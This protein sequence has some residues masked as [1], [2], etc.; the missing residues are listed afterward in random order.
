MAHDQYWNPKS[1][2]HHKNI[3]HETMIPTAMIVKQVCKLTNCGRQ[4]IYHAAIDA[5]FLRARQFVL[6]KTQESTMRPRHEGREILSRR[7]IR[8]TKCSWN[9][10]P[11]PWWWQSTTR[12]TKSSSKSS[13]KYDKEQLEANEDRSTDRPNQKLTS[14][15]AFFTRRPNKLWK[16]NA[17]MSHRW[18]ERSTRFWR[19]LHW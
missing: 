9:D 19:T 1:P 10:W 11:R 7:S 12:L 8:S 14:R 17:R 6:C 3:I 15:A 16:D 18:K 5:P 2:S 13:R 4:T